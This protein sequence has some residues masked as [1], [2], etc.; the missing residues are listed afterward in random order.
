VTALPL[1][2]A[3]VCVTGAARGIGRATAAQ[4]VA[5]GARVVI[6]DIDADEAAEVAADLGPQVRSSALDVTDPES[7]GAFVDVAR[8][9]G[10]IQVLVNN[11]GIQRTG[12]FIDQDLPGQ[13]RELSIDLGGVVIGTRLVLP[14]MVAAGSGHVVNVSSMAGKMT[15]PGA[16]VYTAAKS[17]VV[18]LSRTIRAELVG[19]GVSLTTVLP[20]AVRT[21]LTAGLDIR[22][23]PTS[24]PSD[25]AT[26]I[27]DS[28]RHRRGEV[29]VPSWVAPVGF[30]EQVLP[31]PIGE[32]VKRRVG[33]QRRLTVDNESTRAYQERTA[34][35]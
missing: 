6:G 18:A 25:V 7:F 9:W 13:L 32:F 4:F 2:D 3:V 19:S 30:V 16:A 33:A 24:S 26:A 35:S 27:V 1:R 22:G 15:V 31:E 34:R 20:A 11:A 23:V 21:D 10:P 14:E 28:C 29:T 12:A 17:G 8:A 5:A